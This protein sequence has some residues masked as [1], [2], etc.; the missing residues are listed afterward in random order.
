MRIGSCH[1]GDI[2]AARPRVVARSSPPLSADAA[3]YTSSAPAL[4]S[5]GGQFSHSAILGGGWGVRAA[6]I[7]TAVIVRARR[8]YPSAAAAA[9]HR[10]ATHVSVA[11]A[12]R[13]SDDDAGERMRS[14][15]TLPS[16]VSEARFANK[17]AARKEE[18]SLS[19]PTRCNR[20]PGD[21]E[22]DDETHLAAAAARCSAASAR[23]QSGSP[24][25]TQRNRRA[26]KAE[27]KIVPRRIISR[28]LFGI[29]TV[30]G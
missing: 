6:N 9:S 4:S 22:P 20:R 24:T 23:E 18:F 17:H 14:T 8:G 12:R 21:S 3:E 2:T 16:N 30:V 19:A 1:N 26:V 27:D 7:V 11:A 25:A 10:P 29:S 15:T 5:F 13:R 28:I